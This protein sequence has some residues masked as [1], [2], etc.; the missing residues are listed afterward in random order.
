MVLILWSQGSSFRLGESH[1]QVIGAPKTYTLH[2]GGRQLVV[3]ESFTVLG[4]A[5]RTLEIARPSG[6]DF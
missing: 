6:D 1:S 4:F 2:S 5:V 3:S